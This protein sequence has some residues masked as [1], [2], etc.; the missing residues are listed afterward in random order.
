MLWTLSLSGTLV[1][2]A[3]FAAV[4]EFW[5]RQRRMAL[6]GGAV[7]LSHW[8]FDLV[9]HLR[10]LTVAGDVPKLCFGLLKRPVVERRFEISRALSERL[11]LG[12]SDTRNAPRMSA[13]RVGGDLAAAPGWQLVGCAA[14]G[15]RRFGLAPCPAGVSGHSQN[16]MVGGNE[17]RPPLEAH[18]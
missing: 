10:D 2:R 6:I 15:D 17:P 11:S 1:R 16:S 8:L 9:I 4:V 13:A 12:S 5:M 14:D 18:K 3:G 7:M